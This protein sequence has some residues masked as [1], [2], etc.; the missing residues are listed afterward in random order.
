MHPP[1]SFFIMI[2]I[3]TS[4]IQ[5]TNGTLVCSYVLLSSLSPSLVDDVEIMNLSGKNHRHYIDDEIFWI[6]RLY[7]MASPPKSRN[8]GRKGN[9]RYNIQSIHDKKNT[10]WH[11]YNIHDTF[12]STFCRDRNKYSIIVITDNSLVVI[13]VLIQFTV[14]CIKFY[15][16]HKL[17]ISNK[18][19]GN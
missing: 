4:S 8:S 13:A 6:W 5:T 19:Y 3:I 16:P 11:W 12:K 15:Q 10:G 7:Y 17:N 1:S 2:A 18:I 9:G 14:L